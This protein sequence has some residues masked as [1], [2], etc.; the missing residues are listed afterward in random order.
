MKIIVKVLLVAGI[1]FR[2]G[3]CN[4]QTITFRPYLGISANYVLITGNFDGESYFAVDDEV[5]LVP[6]LDPGFGFGINGGIRFQK[7]ALDFLYKR[8]MHNCSFIDSTGGKA[9][10]NVIK[11]IGF[12]SYLGKVSAIRPFLDFDFSG[13]WMRVTHASYLES[14]LQDDAKATY[15][16]L[17]LGFGGGVEATITDRIHIELEALP[18][19]YLGTDVTGIRKDNY[20]VQKFNSFKFDISVSFIYYF[21]AK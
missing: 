6:K 21:N 20:E 18:A 5:I 3:M 4:S 2:T 17:I 9:T 12:K 7:S 11:F 14:N 15:G 13:A 1:L 16:S 19:W 10:F 8:S